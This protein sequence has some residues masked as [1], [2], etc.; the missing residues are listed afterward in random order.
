MVGPNGAG[1][2]TTLEAVEGYRRPD[3]GGVRVLGYDPRRAGRRIRARIGVM[4]QGAGLYAGIRP[5]EAVRL[6]ASYYPAPEEPLAL[7]ERAGID[8]SSKTP[9]RRMSGGQQQRLSLA[10]ALVGRPDVL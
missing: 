8:P 1:K 9:W 10:L 6:F 4:P 3:S 2:T 5:A 7:L